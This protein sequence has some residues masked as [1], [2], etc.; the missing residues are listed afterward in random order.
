MGNISNND[1]AQAIYLSSKDK[2]LHEL[3]VASKNVVNFLHRRRLLNRS[4]DILLKLNKIINK[5][6]GILMVKISSATKLHENEKEDI[7]VLLKKRYNAHEVLLE[8]HIE[9]KLFGG[10]RIEVNDEVIDLSIKNKINKLQEYL[11]R[12]I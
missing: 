9:E 4:K 12:K 2:S 5:E 3:S 11:T 8:E 6:K 7:K 10:I 1:I